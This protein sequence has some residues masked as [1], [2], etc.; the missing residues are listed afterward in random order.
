MHWVPRATSCVQR[1]YVVCSSNGI[2]WCCGTDLLTGKIKW[3]VVQ[4]KG[5]LVDCVIATT[6]LGTLIDIAAASSYNCPCI[7]WFRPNTLYKQFGRQDSMAS[8]FESWKPW[9][10]DYIKAFQYWKHLSF[11]SSRSSKITCSRPWKNDCHEGTTNPQ[12][13][14]L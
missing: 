6:I 7:L 5:K 10:D 12:L 3:L 13:W 14:G 8:I 11:P 2:Q 1:I 9:L 4:W